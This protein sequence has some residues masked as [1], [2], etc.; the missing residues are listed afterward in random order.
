MLVAMADAKQKAV[1]TAEPGQLQEIQA[2]VS[3][4]K[5][6]SASH[7]LREAINEKL[8]RLRCDRVTEQVARYCA[9]GRSEED[10]DSGLIRNQAFDRDD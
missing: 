10:V 3:S 6:K 4:G 9:E 2:A 5:Y 8:E 7:F 1:F